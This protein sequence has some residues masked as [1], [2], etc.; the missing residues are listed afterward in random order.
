VFVIVLSFA[1]VIGIG[2][3]AEGD[4]RRQC[5]RSLV[6]AIVSDSGQPI[7]FQEEAV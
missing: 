2:R 1:A 5:R 4:S 3:D 6:G 7:W